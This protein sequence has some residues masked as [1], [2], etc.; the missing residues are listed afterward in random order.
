[1]DANQLHE[2]VAARS[3][4]PR[5]QVDS[6]ICALQETVLS[7]VQRNEDVY[8]P[9]FGTWHRASTSHAFDW[10]VDVVPSPEDLGIDY[11]SVHSI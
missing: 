10:T 9:G 3:G 4:L 11:K 7:T 8:L 2:A 1:M 5:D 6:I